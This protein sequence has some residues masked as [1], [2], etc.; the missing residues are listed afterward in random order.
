MLRLVLS[1]VDW[2][3]ALHKPACEADCHESSAA[4]DCAHTTEEQRGLGAGRCGRS[5]RNTCSEG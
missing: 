3:A 4:S 5:A 2:S 1:C